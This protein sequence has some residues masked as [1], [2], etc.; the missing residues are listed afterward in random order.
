M[1]AEVCRSREVAADML[2]SNLPKVGNLSEA[3]TN[4]AGELQDMNIKGL[5]KALEKNMRMEL[6]K[7]WEHKSLTKYIEVNRIPRGL[8]ILLAPS[9]ETRNAEGMGLH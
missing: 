7:W 4:N 3:N 6:T 5:L 2:F 8:R 9:Y 1:S